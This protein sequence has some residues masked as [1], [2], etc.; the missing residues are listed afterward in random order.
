MEV[1]PPG[2]TL[3]HR[4]HVDLR[5]E[6]GAR[7]VFGSCTRVGPA[8]HSDWISAACRSGVR[9]RRGECL[10]RGGEPL[11]SSRFWASARFGDAPAGMWAGPMQPDSR[12][13]APFKLHRG[14]SLAY[15][16]TAKRAWLCTLS[17]D[18]LESISRASFP[19]YYPSKALLFVEGQPATG[20]F[21]ICDGTV[22]LSYGGRITIGRVQGTDVLGLS[23]CLS[24]SCHQFRAEAESPSKINFVPRRAFLR[25]IRKYGELALPLAR[26]MC[27]DFEMT[28]H[29]IDDIAMH[30]TAREKFARLL[31]SLPALHGLAVP[32]EIVIRHVPT[33]EDL[34][35]MIGLSR[36][37][38]TRLFAD[39]KRRGLVRVQGSTVVVTALTALLEAAGKGWTGA[40]PDEQSSAADS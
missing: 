39:F 10:A 9:G 22:R 14:S 32:N 13:R 12:P 5:M 40:M 38:V 37:T 2:L 23:A 16:E 25:L 11:G 34:A 24:G 19:V 8:P 7:L 30:P 33:H 18:V 36:E 29:V 1:R 31:L 6:S 20:V 4:S 15:S 3:A 26:A 35:R 17:P 21:F 27:A 28:R